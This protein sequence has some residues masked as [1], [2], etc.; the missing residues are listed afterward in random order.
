[1]SP[2]IGLIARYDNSGLGTLSW[3][4]ARHLNPHKILLVENGVHQT[5]PERYAHFDTRKVNQRIEAGLRQ[6]LLEDI[7]ILLSIETFYDWSLIK[8][9]RQ[10]GIKTALYTMFEVTP[11][12][13][14]L[15]PDLFICP[16][17]L[18]MEYFPEPK[19]FLPVPVATDRLKW[20]KRTYARTFVH[21]ASHGGIAGRKGTQALLD[22]WSM[23]PHK[24][25]R[26]KIYTWKP[27]TTTDPRI[28]VEV[29]NFK[30]Y[31][32]VWREGD[33]L[34][35]PQGANGICLP[36]IEAW[37]SGLAVITTDIYPFN[38]Y[39]PKELL[40]KPEQTVRRKLASGLKEVDDYVISP[41]NIADKINEYCLQNISRFS[42][43]GRIWAEE[44]SW[45]TLL[46]KYTD[47]LNNL[48]LPSVQK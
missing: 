21:S 6:W 13:L 30:N 8:D 29:V 26:L 48:A 33:V 5:F 16:S 35:Y 31:W 24:D 17:K 44:N 3:E 42:K 10:R 38:E 40:F 9:C 23:V 46:P 27:F 32:Q 43:L 41:R 19:V 4:F 1:M 14:P 2:R 11:D 25:A 20:Q 34:V 39:M 36:I 47:V 22:A 37:S 18:D 15:H 7:D 45:E 12:P 28:T